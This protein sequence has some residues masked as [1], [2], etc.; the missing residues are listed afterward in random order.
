[1]QIKPIEFD[2][3]FFT[4]DRRSVPYVFVHRFCINARL[5]TVYS[6]KN[7]SFFSFLQNGTVISFAAPFDAIKKTPNNN[8]IYIAHTN[9]ILW[10]LME[11]KNRKT[12]KKANSY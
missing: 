12:D 10:K 2:C 1:M 4:I 8:T 6:K 7:L 5:L 3:G 9:D 11:Q